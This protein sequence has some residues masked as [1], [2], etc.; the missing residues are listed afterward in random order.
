MKKTKKCPYCGE[1]IRIEA[2]KCKHCGEW[3]DQDNTKVNESLFNEGIEC[4]NVEVIEDEKPFVEKG[5][6]GYYLERIW[7]FHKFDTNGSVSRSE[8]WKFVLCCNVVC[9]LIM[10]AFLLVISITRVHMKFVHI[11]AMLLSGALLLQYSITSICMAVRRLHDNDKS[12]WLLLLSF[13]PFL[14][15]YLLY[16]LCKKGRTHDVDVPFKSRDTI[17]LVLIIVLSIFFLV[18]SKTIGNE[19]ADETTKP[20]VESELTEG[21][22]ADTDMSELCFDSENGLI[23]TFNFNGY[24]EDAANEYEV[25]M[26]LNFNDGT[27]ADGYIHYG[28]GDETNINP[29]EATYSDGTIKVVEYDENG[30]PTGNDL[31][32]NVDFEDASCSGYYSTFNGRGMSVKM[33]IGQ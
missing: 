12:G 30:D 2:Q 16:L 15:I 22:D 8:Y 3:L 26:V 20:V 33:I 27:K 21:G 18:I 13:I 23:G 9:F 31:T 11:F 19:F 14:N 5:F 4:G 28:E 32:L 1:E 24:M 7:R 25:A 6:F 17:Q 10:T 29:V